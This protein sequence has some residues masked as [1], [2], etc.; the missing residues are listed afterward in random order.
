MTEYKVTFPKNDTDVFALPG[1]SVYECI[2]RAGIR[3]K[4]PCAGQGT[5][6]KCRI[7]ILSGKVP[8]SAQC[9]KIFSEK[10]LSEGWRLACRSH[11]SGEL[12]IEVPDESVPEEGL[13]ILTA[14]DTGVAYEI[15]PLIKKKFLSLPQPTL[16]EPV[17]D[18]E[19]LIRVIQHAR[20][21]LN[22][23][24]QLPD[25]LR[26]NNFS[27]TAVFS[28]KNLVALEDGNTESANFAV[29]VDIGTTTVVAALLDMNSGKQIGCRGM[30]N[31]QVKFGDDV[32]SRIAAQ[33]QSEKNLKSLQKEILT[34]INKLIAELCESLKVASSNIYAVSLAGN[35][36]MENLFLGIPVKALGEIPF[37]P[38]FS[39]SL[40][41]TATELGLQVNPGAEIFMFPVIGGFVGGDIVSGLVASR[42]NERTNPTIFVD[43]GTNGEIVL[44]YKGQL[45][46][47]S[48]AAGPAFE[49]ARIESGM[50]AAAGAIEKVI[51]QDGEVLVNVIR[52]VEPKGLCGSALIDAAAE[53]LRCGLLDE[54]GRIVS[55]EECPLGTPDKLKKRLV[56]SKDGNTFD[57]LLSPAESRKK[58]YLRQKDIR[59]LQLASGAIRAAIN[60]LLKKAGVQESE[61]DSVLVAGGFGYFIRRTHAK[62]IGLIPNLPDAKIRFIGNSSLEGA[63]AVL[64][65]RERLKCAEGIA[66]QVK[67]VEVS[68]DPEFQTE[69]AN[70][71]MFPGQTS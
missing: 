16:E 64:F 41:F 55:P 60:I 70:A 8:P 53:M 32:L 1:T 6:G 28:E 29:A 19:N 57:F 67:Y 43:V 63:K 62:R 51:I 42:L 17:S 25:F 59:E 46:A 50:R 24:K 13:I 36:V 58:I 12:S 15:N 35:T 4:N 7:R 61:I 30:L 33:G 68:L 52:N 3:I 31:P 9:R 18:L 56:A 69:F 22:H 45:F 26:K 14:E 40:R 2:T 44:L 11:V 48:A 21:D 66:A 71:M 37:I 47:A 54:T 38:P 10:E 20:F 65:S 49:G 34:A 39:R 23:L 27:G 5:C